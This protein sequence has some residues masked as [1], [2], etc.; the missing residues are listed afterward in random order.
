MQQ[1]VK[2]ILFW[3]PRVLSLLFAL[4]LSL[5]ALDVFGAGYG[6]WQTILALL[7]HL[8]PVYVLLIIL[9]LAWRWEWI[10]ALGFIGFAIWYLAM[11]WGTFPLTVYLGMVGA[12]ILVG[13]FWLIDWRYHTRL[14]T[15]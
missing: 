5:F 15:T 1:P 2:R 4:F 12:P 9:A 14:H 8:L 13:L 7:I 3:T 6:F 10:G 11:T